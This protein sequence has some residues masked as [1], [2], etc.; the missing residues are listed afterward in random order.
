M[1]FKLIPKNKKGQEL[2]PETH[3]SSPRI[4]PEKKNSRASN[5]KT[6]MDIGQKRPKWS[7][8][9]KSLAQ[10]IARAREIDSKLAKIMKSSRLFADFIP[11]RDRADN[12]IVIREAKK[13]KGRHYDVDLKQFVDW[14]D[15]KTR[16]AAATL[17]LAYDEGTPVQ[18][19]VVL[20]ASFDSADKTIAKIKESPELLKAIQALQGV[21]LTLENGAGEV[22]DIEAE[23]VIQKTGS[24]NWLDSP[25]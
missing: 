13:A 4:S 20:S 17:Q 21:G 23:G 16:L 7:E 14:P 10:K 22:I 11:E 18:R 1:K 9:Q 2:N 5:T 3:N 25:E 24:E 19:Q 6:K 8:G 15:H 12:I